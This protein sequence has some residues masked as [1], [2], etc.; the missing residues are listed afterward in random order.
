MREEE[1]RTTYLPEKHPEHYWPAVILAGKQAAGN[2]EQPKQKLENR[3]R[4]CK[5]NLPYTRGC[6][7]GGGTGDAPL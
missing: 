1:P 6:G 4:M 7:D 5:E 3:E 2:L